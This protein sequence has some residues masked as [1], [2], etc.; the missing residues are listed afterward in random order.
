M[1]KRA[2]D[3]LSATD[4]FDT[5]LRL[6]GIRA[7]S[8]LQLRLKLRR[9]GFDEEVVASTLVRLLADGWL[10]EKSF[11]EQFV[12]SKLRRRN[13]SVRIARELEAAGVTRDMT[14]GALAAVLED[15][16]EE[17]YLREACAKRMRSLTRRGGVEVL[18][19]DEVR[20]KLITHLLQQGYDTSAVLRI[21]AEEIKQA[22]AAGQSSA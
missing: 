16:S 13:G 2:T 3:P 4:C 22:A 9:R 18:Q 11:A 5:S 20:N 12:R 15:V 10:D 21:V 17:D 14:R 8:G 19:S 7:H 6:L 1:N